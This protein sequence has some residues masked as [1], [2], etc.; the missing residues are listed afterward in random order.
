MKEGARITESLSPPGQSRA[1]LR[2]GLPGGLLAFACWIIALMPPTG[3]GILASP[4]FALPL[5]SGAVLLQLRTTAPEL[6]L[7]LAI[8]SLLGTL[9][10]LS[11]RFPDTP[12]ERHF[13]AGGV[14]ALAATCFGVL[15][16]IGMQ[17]HLTLHSNAYDLGI[18]T[19]TFANLAAGRG[20]QSSIR[21]LDH[22]LADHALFTW[23][24]FAPLFRLWPD[25]RLLILLQGLLLL[26]ACWP[27]WLLAR[28]RLSGAGASL[29]VLA[30]AASP[31]LHW[32]GLFDVHEHALT[33]PLAFAL[34]WCWEQRRWGWVWVWGL[35]WLGVKEEVGIVL[36]ALG[37]LLA[38]R[39]PEGSRHGLGLA[40]VAF[41]WLLL[42][43]LVIQPTFRADQTY[44]YIHRY[45]WLGD[46]MGE[47]LRTL[48]TR[49]D[50]WLPRFLELRPWFFVGLLL[51][52][53]AL[54]PLRG[55]R[56]LL[57]MVPT[58]FYSVLSNEPLQTSIYAQYTA[59]Y[60]P[61]LFMALLEGLA[62]PGPGPFTADRGAALA[63]SLTL[64]T[65]L[66]LS[67]LPWGR[68]DMRVAWLRDPVV[69]PDRLTEL[70][71]LAQSDSAMPALL[72]SHLVP[73]VA[74]L[75][76]V[77]VATMAAVQNMAPSPGST[78]WI[79]FDPVRMKSA[80][81]REAM[82]WFN[83]DSMPDTADNAPAARRLEP[84]EVQIHLLP[85]GWALTEPRIADAASPHRM[86]VG[87][88]GPLTRRHLTQ[89]IPLMEIGG[90]P[91][92]VEAEFSG[93]P[94]DTLAVVTVPGSWRLSPE[95]WLLDHWDVWA[96]ALI[97]RSQ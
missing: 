79:L 48:L 78:P 27:L 28:S 21:G 5:D 56:W 22:M 18:F 59:P 84:G 73:H 63:A 70:Q 38:W 68:P 44:Y 33:P 2:W 23:W 29:V 1:L 24:A 47:I 86:L 77:Q 95:E 40:V 65:S 71:R 62:T 13:F 85:R 3:S 51:L 43:T 32:F 67:P 93:V 15:L 88:R 80:E 53:L 46:S 54:L 72:S 25:A 96:P 6:L 14:L 11:V 12:R 83:S 20:L 61:F 45:A 74:T 64:A 34:L 9:I 91:G 97:A 41:S 75:P 57:V 52:P 35:L 69:P 26:L 82:V 60:V 39:D 42:Y 8:V 17:R 36:C 94:P 89:V 30:Y 49:P 16:L 87:W 58:F 81:E 50:R 4:P 90:M 19:Q 7:A 31:I 55:W 37:L 10:G 76:N 66:V 92:W